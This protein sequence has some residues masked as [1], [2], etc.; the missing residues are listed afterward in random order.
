M[1]KIYIKKTP[2]TY[3]FQSFGFGKKDNARAYMIGAIEIAD[4]KTGEV[5]THHDI[6]KDILKRNAL[7]RIVK[8]DGFRN[9]LSNCLKD[10][11]AETKDVYTVILLSSGKVAPKD[12]PK[13]IQNVQ[14]D[15]LFETMDDFLIG[16]GYNIANDILNKIDF[17][18]VDK[19]VVQDTRVGSV[20]FG[21][22]DRKEKVVHLVG[23]FDL[24]RECERSVEHITK[25][26]VEK[27]AHIRATFI[28]HVQDVFMKNDY[29]NETL[30][31]CYEEGYKV[32]VD[33]ILSR[34][35]VT[36][37]NLVK[38][39]QPGVDCMFSDFCEKHSYD[40]M[41]DMMV[42]VEIKIPRP[43]TR[44]SADHSV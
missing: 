18:V 2:I 37:K 34:G 40:I 25:E 32:K 1:E 22:Q 39:L 10:V 6:K 43:D 35:V 44:S 13:R 3:S 17:D 7:I 19:R 4:D 26:C 12:L 11:S 30:R 21:F 31:D 38:K 5:F 9:A 16:T 36:P 14:G 15:Y 8:S 33:V 27:D 41:N 29:T 28:K 42:G 20:I 24:I 23:A